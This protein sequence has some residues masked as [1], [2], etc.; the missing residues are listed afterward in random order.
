MKALSLKQPWAWA[1]ISLG[2]DIENRTWSTSYRGRFLIHA[3]KS[4]DLDGY[5]FVLR[6]AAERRILIPRAADFERG[7][8]VGSAVIRDCVRASDSPWFFGPNGFVLQGAQ[9]LPF[10]ECR[11]Q[12]GW[13]NVPTPAELERAPA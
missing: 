2:K 1:V 3:S 7:G 5:G 13:F 12:V 9:A 10:M 11:G 8:I 6:I 4:F